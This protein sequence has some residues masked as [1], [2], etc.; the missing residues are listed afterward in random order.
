MVWSGLVRYG[1]YGRVR[2]GEVWCGSVR[3]G[4]CGEVR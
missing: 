1:F 3:C 4:F 2:L